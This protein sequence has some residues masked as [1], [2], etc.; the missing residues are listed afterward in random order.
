MFRNE[1]MAVPSRLHIAF[2]IIVAVLSFAANHYSLAAGYVLALVVIVL[3]GL[4]CWFSFR[5]WPTYG[6]N[7]N[8]YV[9]GVY[10]GLMSGLVL[11]YILSILINEGILGILDLL[12]G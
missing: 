11:P 7:V 4:Q 9:F 6:Y 2:A 8:P 5:V 1:K 12:N 10:W 3:I